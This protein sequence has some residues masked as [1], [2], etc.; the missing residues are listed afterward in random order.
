MSFDP[1][2]L[3]LDGF[4]DGRLRIAQPKTGFR[5]GM[6]AVLLAAACPAAPGARVL[7]LGCGAG[8]AS[9]CL[10][11]RVPVVAAALEV[12]PA[13][14]A[15]AR[16]NARRAGM[17]LEVIEGDLTRM[18]AELRARGFDHVIANPPYF[19]AGTPAPDPGRAQA[20]HESADLAAWIDAGLR[21]LVPGGWLTLIQ[22]A[23]RLG[24]LLAALGARAGAVT[25]LPVAGRAGRPAG[26][27]LLRARK[28]GRAPLRLLAPLVLHAAAAHGRDGEDLSD[29]AQAVLRRGEALDFS[30]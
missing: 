28:G 3:S 2:D 19:E 17:A 4:L 12:Q 5:S 9:L 24:D 14:A 30:G 21:R 29:A 10:M 23:E 26:R 18:P 25:I 1:A 16:E 6:D 11:A 13:Y 27:V 22:R 20:R 8:V 7:E 15:L